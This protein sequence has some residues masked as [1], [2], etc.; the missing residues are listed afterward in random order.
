M[1]KSPKQLN[2]LIEEERKITVVPS[3][4][5]FRSILERVTKNDTTR[6]TDQKGATSPFGFFLMITKNKLVMASSIAFLAIIVIVPTVRHASHAPAVE[7]K[8]VQTLDLSSDAQ[9][10]SIKQSSVGTVS[11]DIVS[12]ILTDFAEEDALAQQ[13]YAEDASVDDYTFDDATINS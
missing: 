3:R 8:R 6:N 12:A 13:E 5:E 1:N 4:A 2:T 7:Q 9:A 11:Q 10:Q